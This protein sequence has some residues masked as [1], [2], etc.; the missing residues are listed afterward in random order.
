MARPA[1]TTFV[2]IRWA[3]ISFLTFLSAAS[4]VLL[5]MTMFWSKRLGIRAWKSTSLPVLQC[6]DERS[7]DV[8]G[9]MSDVDAVKL[10]A[11]HIEV[12]LRS[13]GGT[14]LV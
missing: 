14:R 7:V 10:R 8:L 13:R 3:Y 2:K 12:R 11:K 9:D 6:L 1:D 4:G 5:F